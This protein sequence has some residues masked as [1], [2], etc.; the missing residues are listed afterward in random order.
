MLIFIAWFNLYPKKILFIIS[1][2]NYFLIIISCLDLHVESN[3]WLSEDMFLFSRCGW[4]CIHWIVHGTHS[5]TKSLVIRIYVDHSYNYP[6]PSN[7]HNFWCLSIFS[8]YLWYSIY[9]YICVYLPWGSLISLI[10][11]QW[12]VGSKLLT[13]G[14]LCKNNIKRKYL[15]GLDFLATITIY[16]NAQCTI[17][18][19]QD[20]HLGKSPQEM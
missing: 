12:L 1:Q 15:L 18:W 19:Y 2:L 3:S 5:D 16:F 8:K 7:F 6:F 10:F 4:Q 9:Y 17:T 13:T 20:C 11:K 14:Q